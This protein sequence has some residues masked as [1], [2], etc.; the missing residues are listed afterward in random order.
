MVI[1]TLFH[2]FTLTSI[3]P[4]YPIMTIESG[5]PQLV[6]YTVHPSSKLGLWH[7][8]IT[9]S[10]ANIKPCVCMMTRVLIQ[11]LF[12]ASS[13]VTAK[14]PQYPFAFKWLNFEPFSWFHFPVHHPPPRTPNPPPVSSYPIA[15]SDRLIWRKAS[16]NPTHY[17]ANRWSRWIS[18]N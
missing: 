5:C 6:W 4:M 15:P 11:Q 9:I 18:V 14:W 3:K 10:S 12:L 7:N 2:G 1:Y 13:Y 16:P 8:A 17:S